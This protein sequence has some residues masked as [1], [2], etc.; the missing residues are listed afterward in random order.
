[1]TT[2]HHASTTTEHHASM[3]TEHHASTTTEHHAAANVRFAGAR[4]V[5][6]A[7]TLL[8]SYLVT[9]FASQHSALSPKLHLTIWYK[10]EARRQGDQS[11]IVTSNATLGGVSEG[12]RK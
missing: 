9:Q 4:T 3:T 5:F 2:E 12:E 6:H 7:F 8:T 10:P 1:M 11:P